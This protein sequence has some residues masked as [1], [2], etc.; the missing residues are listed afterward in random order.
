L[1]PFLSIIIPALNE[2]SRLP[3]SLKSILTFL[4]SQPFEAEVLVVD[5]GSQ[6]GTLALARSYAARHPTL[7]VLQEPRRGKGAA[8]RCG[9]LAAGGEYRFIADADLSMPIDQVLRFLPPQLPDVDIAIASREAPG[10]VR[11]GEPPY[12]HLIGRGFNLLVRWIAVPGFQDTQCGFKAF[13]DRAAIDL[14]QA[15]QLDGWT[16]D[17]EVLFIGLRRGYRIVEVPIP[18]YYNPGSRVRVVRDS[19]AMLRDLFRIRR[20]WGL[21]AYE[22]AARREPTA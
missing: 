8:V 12:R 21:G 10:A 2:E 20:L 22:P 18:W 7:R 13:R 17:V 19:I 16:F 15:Q 1:Q 5:N 6:D 11:Y 3:A 14:F 9:M 4:E